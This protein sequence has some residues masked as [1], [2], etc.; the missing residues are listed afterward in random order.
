M[1]FLKRERVVTSQILKIGNR[2]IQWPS[3][4]KPRALELAAEKRAR[5]GEAN[6]RGKTGHG[7]CPCL[8]RMYLAECYVMGVDP[9]FFMVFI[10][11]I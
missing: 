10:H 5:V 1:K 11:A 6:G 2:S 3:G 4:P 8:P 9:K 7:H